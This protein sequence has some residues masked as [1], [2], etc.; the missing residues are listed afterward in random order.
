MKLNI[1]KLKKTKNL[2]KKA[3][4]LLILSKKCDIMI[5]VIYEGE[6]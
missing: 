3:K 5:N 4:K 6:P 2:E 1:N